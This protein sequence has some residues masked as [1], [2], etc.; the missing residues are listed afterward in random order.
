LDRENALHQARSLHG[1]AEAGLAALELQAVREVWQACS[2]AR[3]ALRKHDYAR[4]L[5]AASQEAYDSTLGSYRSAGRG[6]VLDLLTA[7]RD[8]A[9]ARTTL[10]ESRAELLTA[11]AALTFA[12][13]D[14]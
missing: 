2:D 11:F 4:A 13:G 1:A 8:L 3:T 12:A 7:Q 9:R 6:T 14:G 10:I 5:L